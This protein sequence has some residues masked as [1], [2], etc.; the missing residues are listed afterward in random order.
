MA[1]DASSELYILPFKSSVENRFQNL[2]K[3]GTS[4][5]TSND[6]SKDLLEIRITEIPPDLDGDTI[7][8]TGS[9]SD[10]T[11]HDF[12]SVMRHQEIDFDSLNQILYKDVVLL[13]SAA[14]EEAKLGLGSDTALF[15]EVKNI[16]TVPVIMFSKDEAAEE[17]VSDTHDILGDDL[18]YTNHIKED[19]NLSDFIMFKDDNDVLNSV[20]VLGVD[21][22]ENIE[23]VWIS[24]QCS[25]PLPEVGLD[26]NELLGGDGGHLVPVKLEN[27]VV[28]IDAAPSS[29]SAS[30]NDK[31]TIPIEDSTDTSLERPSVIS[32]A[33]PNGKG[34]ETNGTQAR[35]KTHM[36]CAGQKASSSKT[37]L[38]STNSRSLLKT[39]FAKKGSKF[40][41]LKPK[42]FGKQALKEEHIS[43]LI[44]HSSKQSKH[45]VQLVRKPGLKKGCSSKSPSLAVVA[46]SSDTSKD[47]TE[48]VVST[49]RGDQIFKG[50]TSELI[51]A[52]P[53]LWCDDSSQGSDSNTMDEDDFLDSQ[54][55]TDALQRLGVPSLSWVQNKPDDQ[56]MWYCPERGCKKLFPLL[57]QLKV[58]ILGHYGVRPYKVCI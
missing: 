5:G 3:N 25:E 56:K 8:Q 10:S 52:T 35:R 21:S 30:R 2:C 14:S 12:G 51:N 48:I 6:I 42:L 11:V 58:H 32:I 22:V 24:E 23:N 4:I 9:I 36:S 16:S 19:K 43:S 15:G 28:F 27:N 13:S 26:P 53:N 18:K 45:D 7:L 1:L 37:L 33:V 54:P 41:P 40:V 31:R 49:A 47:L 29:N 46:I 20:Q 38:S 44:S 50:K 34:C 17:I 57:N 39:S 55:L